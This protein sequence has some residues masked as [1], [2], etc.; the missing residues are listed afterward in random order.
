[1]V[2]LPFVLIT[3]GISVPFRIPSDLR[4]FQPRRLTELDH[5]TGVSVKYHTS[6]L[7]YGVRT[8][9][10]VVTGKI[11]LFVSYAMLYVNHRK[12]ARTFSW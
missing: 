12:M 7:Q 1:M 6:A 5:E 3:D 8:Q 10:L 2:G 11:C 4:D 9:I